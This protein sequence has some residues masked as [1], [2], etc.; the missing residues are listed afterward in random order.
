MYSRLAIGRNDNYNLKNKKIQTSGGFII[1][2]GKKAQSSGRQWEWLG[3]FRELG[4]FGG[5]I[6][7]VRNKRLSHPAV[8]GNDWGGST[9]LDVLAGSLLQPEKK[10]P[11][12][13]GC[14]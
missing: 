5:F 12:V 9:S 4:C 10:G 2:S 14:R 1:T 8:S 3:G 7:Y 6:I 13:C 11:V